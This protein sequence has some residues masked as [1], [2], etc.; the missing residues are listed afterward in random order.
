MWYVDMVEKF[1]QS[2]RKRKKGEFSDFEC[3]SPVG[4]RQTGM[5]ISQIA[6]LLGF[7]HSTICG[8]YREW[9]EKETTS[10]EEQFSG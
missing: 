6:N 9:S 7:S 8:V 3:G 1:K 10:S 5:S 4:A 2:N